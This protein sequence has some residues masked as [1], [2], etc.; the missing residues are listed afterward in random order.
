LTDAR[1]KATF[2]REEY[3]QWRRQKFVDNAGFFALFADFKA[4]LPLLST[5]AISLFIYIGLHSNNKTGECYH[6]LHT[7]SKTFGKSKRT[8]ISWFNELQSHGLIERLQLEFN[9]VSHTFIRPYTYMNSE[10]TLDTD[11]EEKRD[12]D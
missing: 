5:G 4:Y 3:Y 12:D 9:G 8:I 7:I 6:D 11:R 2:Y 1:E 10:N